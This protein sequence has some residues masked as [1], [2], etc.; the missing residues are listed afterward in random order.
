[1]FHQLSSLHAECVEGE[2]FVEFALTRWIVPEI[3][4]NDCHDIAFR[5][6]NFKSISRWSGAESETLHW[7]RSLREE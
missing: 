3:L 1:M 7:A 6:D 5:G 2:C 4:V